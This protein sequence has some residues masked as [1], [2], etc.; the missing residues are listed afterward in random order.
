M[1]VSV[2]FLMGRSE[3]KH[4][5]FI[6]LIIGIWNDDKILKQRAAW[7]EAN[8]LEL[9]QQLKLARENLH[10]GAQRLLQTEVSRSVVI[11]E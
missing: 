1:Q 4:S 9:K 8:L 6:Y 3:G 2:M 10:L 7:Y 5:D 11:V